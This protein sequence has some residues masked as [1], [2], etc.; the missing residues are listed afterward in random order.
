MP[1]ITLSNSSIISCEQGALLSDVIKLHEQLHLPCG[2]H[3][4]CGKCVVHVRGDISAY[5]EEELL[6]LTKKERD[7]GLR[8]ACC[9]T[10]ERDAEILTADSTEL[11]ISSGGYMP[12]FK[13]APTFK[14]YGF[15]VDIGTTT[16]AAHLY[17]HDGLLAHSGMANPQASFGA[18]VISRIGSSM[19][20]NAV[21]LA[22]TIR[23][24]INELITDMCAAADILPTD[25]DS[26]VITGN[27][28]MLYLLTAADPSALSAAP[29]EADRLFDEQQS[30]A[31]LN[32][33]C[34]DASVYLPRC[35]S[36]FV[37]ADI[38]TAAVAAGI[39]K[40][41]TAL[42]VDIG[43]NGELLLKN[44]EQYTCCSTAAGPAFEGAHLSSGMAG[45]PGAIDS[46]Y[47]QDGK[48]KYSVIG[49]GKPLG[50]CGSGVIDLVAALVKTE[51]I[52][53]TGYLEETYT[54]DEVTFTQKDVRQIQL[55]KSAIS[56]GIT[57]LLQVAGLSF[58]DIETLY[59]CGGF[60]SYVDM[61][62]AAAI[63]LI[64][65]QLVGRANVLGNSALCGSAMMLL[66]PQFRQMGRDITA[67][68]KTVDLAANPVFVDAYS[69]GMFF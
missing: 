9:A 47:V 55:A 7:S 44:G 56:A 20:G 41:G 48:L 69:E 34:P 16:V 24:G 15:A 59:I 4:R 51:I 63:G 38:T 53:E 18:D 13:N 11:V 65:P 2:G 43:T 14:K 28:A 30:G 60:G 8:L 25:I 22:T 1:N 52:D 50:I 64:P 17:G 21:A 31:G 6:Y 58:E 54:L 68:A 27:T 57:T 10:V 42:L 29:F 32:L 19:G 36:A 46:V 3:R 26:G 37:G 45:K 40:H 49:G 35:F 62:N 67:A 66:N 61:Q 5:S 23:N 33:I 12:H 39:D